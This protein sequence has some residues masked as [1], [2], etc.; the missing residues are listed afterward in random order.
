MSVLI[1]SLVCMVFLN[2]DWYNLEKSKRVKP[3]RCGEFD[4]CIERAESSQGLPLKK[5]EKYARREDA[6]LHALELERQML[7][8][9]EKTGIAS[10]KPI[11]DHI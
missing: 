11:S 4:G 7:K 5:R 2:R 3:F 6:I 1:F 9:Q 10:D 8:K